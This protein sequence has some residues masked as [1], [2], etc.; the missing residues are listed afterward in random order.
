M[1]VTA[2]DTV[3]TSQETSVTSSSTVATPVCFTAMEDHPETFNA[4]GVVHVNLTCSYS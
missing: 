4:S 2:A 1:L 3:T